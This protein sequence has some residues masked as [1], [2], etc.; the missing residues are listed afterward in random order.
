M[1]GQQLVKL[2]E[3]DVFRPAVMDT[4]INEF[5][6]PKNQFL[7]TDK[8]LPFR[9]V[10]KDV[11]IDLINNGAFGRTTPIN[12]SGEHRQ[13]P[14]TGHSFKEHIPGN[15]RESVVYGEDVL[16]K[17][18]DPQ[19]PTQKA[20][21]KLAVMAAKLL[22]R[23]INVLIEYLTAKTIIN[24]KYSEARF[25]VNYE[26][27]P[28]IPSRFF[29][30]VTSSP[31]WVTGGTWADRANSTPFQDVMEAKNKFA[32]DGYVADTVTMTRKTAMDFL[33]SAA[34]QAMIK[35]SPELVGKSA[36]VEAVFEPLTGLMLEIDDRLYS[37]ETPFSAASAASD[38]TLDV[39]SA[40]EFAAGDVLTLKNSFNQEEQVTISSI[41]VNVISLTAG[42]VFAYAKGD[43][44]IARKR[45]LPD[46][47]FVMKGETDQ[48]MNPNNWVS[49]P[50]LTK[51]ESWKR[52]LPGRYSWTW[53]QER[54]PYI[55]EIG[56]GIS[57]GPKVS[58]C[59]WMTV[60]VYA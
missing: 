40:S 60:R 59:D 31:G 16:A 35:A 50:T 29:R 20:G 36:R 51:A 8:F 12:L 42:T 34:T 52:Q 10:D 27:D 48:A 24:G 47:Y 45:Y 14:I 6:E 25:G 7:L 18:V 41:S 38:T 19:M 32:D 58:L 1:T 53:F 5:P 54:P 28:K 39:E 26:Y 4:V 2:M 3:A 46:G 11:M 37:E 21:E 15:W 49:T 9:E 33:L 17:A 23:R 57:G 13:I 22:D 44:V 56:A 43:R 30:N 55:L